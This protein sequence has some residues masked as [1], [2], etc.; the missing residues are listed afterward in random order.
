MTPSIADVVIFFICFRFDYCHQIYWFAAICLPMSMRA[1]L[2]FHPQFEAPVF[3][4][5]VFFR[6]CFSREFSCYR[7]LPIIEMSS[8]RGPM[9]WP[10]PYRCPTEYFRHLL[11]SSFLISDLLELIYSRIYFS[12]SIS[13]LFVFAFA[14]V[15]CFTVDTSK[16]SNEIGRFSIDLIKSNRFISSFLGC[17]M[18]SHFNTHSHI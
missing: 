12:V 2:P 5:W 15:L 4:P 7:I 1:L 10:R 14:F 17:V 9:K 16:S 8:S 11:I 3:G 6:R 18:K 13:R